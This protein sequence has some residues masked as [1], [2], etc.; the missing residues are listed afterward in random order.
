MGV[1]DAFGVNTE[2]GCGC[3]GRALRRTR[4]GEGN[5]VVAS[6]PAKVCGRDRGT[7]LDRVLTGMLAGAGGVPLICMDSG[8]MGIRSPAGG[9]GPSYFWSEAPPAAGDGASPNGGGGETG[10]VGV[11]HVG[12]CHTESSPEGVACHGRRHGRHGRY[13]HIRSG[14]SLCGRRRHSRRRRR[15]FR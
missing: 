13:H 4:V 1:D 11:V 3:G 2:I 6:R 10:A 14:W 12:W 15:R 9:P 5:G 8:G 7:D